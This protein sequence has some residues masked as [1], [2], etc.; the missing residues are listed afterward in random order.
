MDASRP[1]LA[2]P[3]RSALPSFLSLRFVADAKTRE[4]RRMRKGVKDSATSVAWSFE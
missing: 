3:L 2:S 1:P 4:K